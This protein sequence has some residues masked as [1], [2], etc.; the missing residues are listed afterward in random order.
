MTNETFFLV[1]FNFVIFF[2]FAEYGL[3]QGGEAA[4]PIEITGSS[5]QTNM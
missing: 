4:G 1:F 5:G 3:R 2:A